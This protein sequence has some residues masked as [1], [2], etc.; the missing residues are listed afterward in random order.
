M[1]T[2]SRSLTCDELNI[3]LLLR[4][5][6]KDY[7]WGGN[8]LQQEY[9]KL[10]EME[11]LA[12]SWE[13]ST[14]PDGLS[15]IA[16]GPWQGRS[17][18]EYVE[19]YPEVLGKHA[20]NPLGIP[21]LVKLIDAHRDLSLQVHPDD[22]YAMEHEREAGKTE[23]WY[24]LDARPGAELIYGFSHDITE[25]QLREY[26]RDGSI[27]NHVQRLPVRKDDVF[28]VRPGTIHAIGAGVVLA[29][30]QQS[31][32]VTYR[33]YDYDRIDKNGEPRALHVEKALQVLDRKA[34]PQVRQQLRLL[35]YTPGAARES[36]CQCPYFHVERVL[37]SKELEWEVPGQNFQIL[38]MLSGDAGLHY[39]E[40][41][42][43]GQS[44]SL[45]KGDCVF[46]P[47]DMGKLRMA[48]NGQF[49]QISC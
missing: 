47:A 29:E 41:E 3:P 33:V 28:F 34:A 31:S 48:G 21:V 45:G 49:L 37:L 39:G 22:D 40:R 42:N 26:V 13:C 27:V 38:L 8:R 14:H 44:L 20:G 24:V 5:A 12:E 16:N 17:L 46:L 10:P 11:M 35:R 36:L 43:K 15:F 6:G 23:L 32:N 4:P 9:G 19:R 18:K 7:L 1:L 30:I 25:E 2:T